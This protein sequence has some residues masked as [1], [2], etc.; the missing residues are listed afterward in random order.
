MK[1]PSFVLLIVAWLALVSPIRAAD[2]PASG[3]A[4]SAAEIARLIEQLGDKQ[5]EV[6]ERAQEQLIKRG[7]EAFDLLADAQEHDDPEIAMQAGYLVRTI[8]AEWTRDG[9]PRAVQQILK[10]Y[11]S[12]ADDRRLQRI[13][14]LADLPGDQGLPWLCRLVRFEKS[15]VV[16]RQAALAIMDQPMPKDPQAWA[17]RAETIRASVAHA[18]RPAAR[19]LLAYVQMQGDPGAA[20][21]TW[22][23]LVSA[24]RKVLE[25]HPQETAPG[26]VSDMLK[27]KVELLD[28]LGRGKETTEVVRQMID[29]ERGDSASLS[30]LV[31][32]LSTRKSWDAIDEVSRRFAASFDLDAVL[33]Y[34]LC[35]ARRAQGNTE[36]AEATATKALQLGGDNPQEHAAVV[37]RLV[38]RGLMEWAERE[39]RRIIAIGP[40]GSA[41]DVRARRY[42][43]ENLHDRRRDREAADL[44]NELLT[45]ADKDPNVMQRVRASRQQGEANANLFRSSMSFYYACDA[46]AAGDRAKQKQYLEKALEQDRSNVD[47]LIA[48]YRL[49]D[50]GS[51]ERNQIVALIKEVIETCRGQIENSPDEPTFYNQVAWLVANTEGD[52]DEAI[53]LSQKSVDLARAEGESPKRVGGLLDTLG[54]CYFAKKDYASAVRCQSEAAALD[55]HTVS[56]T[57]QLKVFR[58]ALDRQNSRQP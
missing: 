20:L 31:E 26:I 11:D 12:Q 1:L 10:D 34:T 5:Y 38:E 9:D 41:T 42:L 30:E 17:R 8:R 21:A 55:P 43:A 53:R 7:Y 58:E 28:R 54:H 39:L 46:E 16:S 50:S 19:W 48:L 4:E 3:S 29:C 27:R 22:S 49:T 24:E 15:H 23:E 44:L 45:A 32:W 36:Q 33:L 57:R 37:D 51:A 47:V 2:E 40:L 56:I 6:R 25:E 35:E 13:R 14:Q 18:R 52:I